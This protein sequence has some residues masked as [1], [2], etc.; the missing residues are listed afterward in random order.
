MEYTV[1]SKR[2]LGKF[3]DENVVVGWDDPRFPT[4][5]GCLNRGLTVEAITEFMLDQGPSRR[6]NLMEW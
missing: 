1:L 5:Q 3:V 2:K 6:A 4:I